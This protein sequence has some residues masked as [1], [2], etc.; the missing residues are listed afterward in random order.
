MDSA[1]HSKF[2]FEVL[3]PLQEKIQFVVLEFGEL[4]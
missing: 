3:V 4:G 2:V 1:M